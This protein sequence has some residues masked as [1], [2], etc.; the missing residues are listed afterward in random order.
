MIKLEMKLLY[1][2]IFS[3][4]FEVLFKTK[5]LSSSNTTDFANKLSMLIAS[6]Q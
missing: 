1:M 6:V 3:H 4:K 5:Q 2:L